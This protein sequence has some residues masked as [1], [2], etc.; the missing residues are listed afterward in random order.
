M[1]HKF[2]IMLVSAPCLLAVAG[3]AFAQGGAGG[4]SVAPA[5]NPLPAPSGMSAGAGPGTVVSSTT[6]TQQ[7]PSAEIMPGAGSAQPPSVKAGGDPAS[8]VVFGGF[9]SASMLGLR[10]RFA[11]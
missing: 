3:S 6:T 5:N 1:S 4:P 9:L 2:R 10:R 8:F 7:T 11:R